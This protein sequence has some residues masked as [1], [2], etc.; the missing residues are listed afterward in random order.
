[1]K[2]SFILHI[3]SLVILEKMPDEIAGKF[4]KLIYQ[5][6][7]TGEI[8]NSDFALDMAITPFINQFKRDNNRFESVSALRK[9]AGAKGG[10]QKVANATKSKR[11]V[12]KVAD[13]DSKNGSDSVSD[14]KTEIEKSFDAFF[15][16]RKKINKPLTDHAKDLLNLK[17]NELA[18]ENDALKIKIL[19]QSTMNC[20]Q[21]VFPL[22]QDA[23][24][25]STPEV[26]LG[27]DWLKNTTRQ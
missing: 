3:D 1:M 16:M 23:V 8:D 24:S 21:G 2:K 15:E 12:A 26:K 6:Q 11:K 14:S 22:K 7:K 17:L 5:Y 27:S 18:P 9:E 25:T 20:W 10:K 13:S 19:N 4:I